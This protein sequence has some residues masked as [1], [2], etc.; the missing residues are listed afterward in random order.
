MSAEAVDRFYRG[1]QGALDQ[2]AKNRRD[3]RPPT[4][5]EVHVHR[6][7]VGRE[8]RRYAARQ[9]GAFRLA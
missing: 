6:W 7:L 3:P 8:M 1:V 5:T 9:A 2:L 4:P